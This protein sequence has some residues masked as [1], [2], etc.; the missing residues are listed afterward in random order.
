MFRELG[1]SAGAP[2][3]ASSSTNDDG[4]VWTDDASGFHDRSTYADYHQGSRPGRNPGTANSD[5]PCGNA[6]WTGATSNAKHANGTLSDFACNVLGAK[7]KLGAPK[8]DRRR[9]ACRVTDCGIGR[10]AFEYSG[11]SYKQSRNQ[12]VGKCGQYAHPSEFG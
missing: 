12:S 10:A 2:D 5:E 11:N 3:G 7:W 9:C 1:G 4:S 8:R 6:D